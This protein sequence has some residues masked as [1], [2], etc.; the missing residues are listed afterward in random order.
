MF[1]SCGFQ[2]TLPSDFAKTTDSWGIYDLFIL[3]PACVPLAF[4]FLIS[5]RNLSLLV[6]QLPFS[7]NPVYH[8][9]TL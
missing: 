1:F 9:T 4:I 2:E 7:L 8:L 6:P 5:S 3:A